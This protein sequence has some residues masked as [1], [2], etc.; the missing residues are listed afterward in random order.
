[1]KLE[2]CQQNFEKK[3]INIKFIQNLPSG[4]RVVPCGLTDR[5]DEAIFESPKLTGSM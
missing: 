4:S 2:L 3:R 1:M 5:H